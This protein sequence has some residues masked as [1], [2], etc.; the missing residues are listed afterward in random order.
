MRVVFAG[1]WH[2][3]HEAAW[4]AVKEAKSLGVSWIVHVGDFFYTGHWGHNFLN[5]LQRALHRHDM[6]LVFVRGNHDDTNALRRF[7]VSA[8]EK[9]TLS[10]EGFVPMRERVFWAPD[11]LLWEW[12]GVKFA[13]LGGAPS[14]DRAHRKVDVSW[15]ADEETTDYAVDKVIAGGKVDVLVAHDIPVHVPLR[16]MYKHDFGMPNRVRLQRAVDGARPDWMFSGHYHAFQM[17]QMTHRDGSHGTSVVLDCGD[18]TGQES[19]PARLARSLFFAEVENGRFSQLRQ[20]A[21]S[22]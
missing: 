22:F 7:E 12:E 13:A 17:E 20:S 10:P 1:D 15:W 2:A 8:N 18:Y 9:G 11:G 21:F 16:T 3:S 6:K 4:A 19:N 14:I 5:S